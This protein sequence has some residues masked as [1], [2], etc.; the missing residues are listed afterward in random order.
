[1]AKRCIKIQ[2]SCEIRELLRT[3]KEGPWSVKNKKN[4]MWHLYHC[5]KVV[6]SCPF[7]KN[8]P[9]KTKNIKKKKRGNKQNQ[10]STWVSAEC[11][12]S[13]SLSTWD[14]K[15]P[16]FWER[17]S[18]SI[19]VPCKIGKRLSLPPISPP[20]PP[21][22]SFFPPCSIHCV[23]IGFSSY[24]FLFPHI[25]LGGGGGGG[26]GRGGLWWRSGNC[27]FCCKENS[28]ISE[29]KVIVF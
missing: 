10:Q 18:A 1:M 14:S 5:G 9:S 21:S 17:P 29:H 20:P 19:Y 23:S 2:F 8:L 25:L 4:K 13:T 15:S 7:T 3:W 24:L 27:C 28:G 6:F 11:F 16:A 22:P 12:A 26:R